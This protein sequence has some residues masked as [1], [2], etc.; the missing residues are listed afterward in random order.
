MKRNRIG[1][2]QVEVTRIAFGCS[3]LGNLYR[4]IADAEPRA[5]L[6]RAW[7][8]GIRY[9]DTAP[10]YGR[11]L[12]EARLGQFLQ[13]RNRSDYAISTKVGRLL[14]PGPALAEAHWPAAADT[15]LL[16]V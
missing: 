3:G 4:R 2:T 6:E 12:S 13:G 15:A 1:A 7:D 9:F 10:H 5:V 14:S 11:G 16:P 8:R